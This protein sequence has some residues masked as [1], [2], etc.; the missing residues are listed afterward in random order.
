MTRSWSTR[1]LSSD[2]VTAIKSKTDSLV[3]AKHTNTSLHKSGTAAR[4]NALYRCHNDRSPQIKRISKV[5]QKLLQHKHDR[6]HGK[7]HHEQREQQHEGLL[8]NYLKSSPSDI[9]S[10]AM[11]RVDSRTN[12]MSPFSMHKSGV[13]SDFLSIPMASPSQRVASDNRLSD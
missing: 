13:R 6:Q 5:S 4:R 2:R 3:K 11:T 10:A 1:M 9:E 12:N 7:Q 8:G